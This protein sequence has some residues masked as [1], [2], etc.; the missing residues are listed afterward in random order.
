MTLTWISGVKMQCWSCERLFVMLIWSLR[1]H[2]KIIGLVKR[3]YWR[4]EHFVVILTL[5]NIWLTKM[6]YWRRK[7]VLNYILKLLWC[8]ISRLCNFRNTWQN[9]HLVERWHWRCEHLETCYCEFMFWLRE[10]FKENRIYKQLILM[11]WSPL[12]FILL[13]TCS[14]KNR[15]NRYD[16]PLLLFLQIIY[17]FYNV[18]LCYFVNAA[19]NKS[20][21]HRCDINI[22]KTF[23]CFC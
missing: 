22:V 7:R 10:C 9:L 6:S 23:C 13:L 17:I 5:L 15:F 1:E 18:S 19:T 20:S 3:C 12:L 2:S 4:G 8:L 16:K 11:S 14:Q 21:Y